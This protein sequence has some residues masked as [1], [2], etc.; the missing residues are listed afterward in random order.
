MGGRSADNLESTGADTIE[1]TLGCQKDRLLE[2]WK[3]ERRL[4]ST[5]DKKVTLRV[6]CSQ[7]AWAPKMSMENLVDH[8]S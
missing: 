2:G 3:Q 5:I 7:A 6:I 4:E 8:R 1:R